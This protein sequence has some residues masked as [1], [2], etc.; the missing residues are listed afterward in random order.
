MKCYIITYDLNKG[1]KSDYQDLYIAIKWYSWR[2]HINESVWAIVANDSSTAAG[3]R[4]DLLSKVDPQ[5][6]VFVIRSWK[7]AARFNVLCNS[8]WL[9]NNL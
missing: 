1:I 6:S 9:K 2:A 3:V 4:D 5:D 7:E 8:E